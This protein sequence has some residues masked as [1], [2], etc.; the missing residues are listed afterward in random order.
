MLDVQRYVVFTAK[1]ATKAF[2]AIGFAP[3]QMKI[4]MRRFNMI[5]QIVEY[6]QECHTIS[7]T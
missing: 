4:A 5:P 1:L 2:V 6:Q 7:A 3:S